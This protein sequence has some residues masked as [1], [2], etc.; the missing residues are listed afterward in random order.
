MRV[1]IATLLLIASSIFWTMLTNSPGISLFDVFDM[2]DAAAFRVEILKILW[3]SSTCSLLTIGV[4]CIFAIDSDRR[5][6][7]SS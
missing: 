2:P 7:A 1:P 4:K 6:M 5:M 3:A